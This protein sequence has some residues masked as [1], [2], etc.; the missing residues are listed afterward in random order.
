MY[1]IQ[2]KLDYFDDDYLGVFIFSFE[3]TE[4]AKNFIL[5]IEEDSFFEKNRFYISKPNFCY[6][7]DE[8]LGIK[9]YNFLYKGRLIKEEEILNSI[10]KLK[11]IFEN[12][13]DNLNNAILIYN[14]KKQINKHYFRKRLYKYER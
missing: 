13:K 1:Y 14:K 10:I 7:L 2:L 8:K 9:K 5:K 11:N 4:I 3:T 6:S 12:I